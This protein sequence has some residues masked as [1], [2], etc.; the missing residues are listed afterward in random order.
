MLLGNKKKKKKL[1]TIS[2]EQLLTLLAEWYPE[3]RNKNS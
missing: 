2:K 3:I 1:G